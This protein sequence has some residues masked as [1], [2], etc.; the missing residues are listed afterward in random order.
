M[1]RTHYKLILFAAICLSFFQLES[2][3]GQEACIEAFKNVETLSSL[4]SREQRFYEKSVLNIK[5][6]FLQGLELPE[7][8]S[9]LYVPDL[10][11]TDIGTRPDQMQFP[12]LL[13]DNE[14]ETY[15]PIFFHELGHQVFYYNIEKSFIALAGLREQ[16]D[17]DPDKHRGDFEMIG[18]L[19]SD[20]QEVFADLVSFVNS[21]SDQPLSTVL[22]LLTKSHHPYRMF[23][24]NTEYGLTERPVNPHDSLYDVRIEL[25]KIWKAN[26]EKPQFR[27]HF[28]A[29][30]LGVFGKVLEGQFKDGDV[31]RSAEAKAKSYIEALRS[32]FSP[33]LTTEK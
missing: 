21:D 22:S 24:V 26:K 25:G 33:S 20:I 7:H 13:A 28:L 17:H 31:S 14:Y 8:R 1:P 23:D 16:I 2:A 18:Q 11:A 27:I 15:K 10:K 30:V 6:T 32:K 9:V 12:L 4:T 3:F 19:T 5:T 29:S